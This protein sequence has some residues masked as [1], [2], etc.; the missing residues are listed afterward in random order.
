MTLEGLRDY[1]HLHEWDCLSMRNVLFL[2][3]LWL[4]EL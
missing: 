1:E 2:V 3:Q 4:Y